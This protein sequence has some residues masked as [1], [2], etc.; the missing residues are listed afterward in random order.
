MKFQKLVK[1]E[2]NFKVGD[3]VIDKS[4]G[5]RFAKIVD[6]TNDGRD[7]VYKIQIICNTKG[8]D[9][10]SS[11]KIEIKPKKYNALYPIDDQLNKSISWVESA[12][13]YKKECLERLQSI[14]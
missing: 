11:G 9:L 6:I 8:E 13:Q 1:A 14:K 2:E 5:E 3:I 4:I 7:D 12:L 10:L